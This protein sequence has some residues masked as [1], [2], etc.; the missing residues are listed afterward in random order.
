M[1]SEN[2][3]HQ[4]YTTTKEC[5]VQTDDSVGESLNC[6]Y[7]S[8][9]IH[10]D[11]N[12]FDNL[13]S[14]KHPLIVE[15]TLITLES[16]LNAKDFQTSRKEVLVSIKNHPTLPVKPPPPTESVKE[17]ED[18]D[19][20]VEILLSTETD[21]TVSS[22]NQQ[23]EI[24]T[25]LNDLR[26]LFFRF[27]I[28]PK[29]QLPPAD[30]I[31]QDDYSND[32]YYMRR[33][34]YNFEKYDPIVDISGPTVKRPIED[35]IVEETKDEDD[36]VSQKSFDSLSSKPMTPLEKI[37]KLKTCFQEVSLPDNVRLGL[38]IS[39]IALNHRITSVDDC[40]TY[41]CNASLKV[42][43]FFQVSEV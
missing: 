38:R 23:S 9:E 3:D 33:N 40:V 1:N 15:P 10:S 14:T 5:C 25:N 16:L 34:V 20:P 32:S 18:S 31:S 8:N 41:L 42:K 30:T 4:T 11:P 24:H 7:N 29:K 22:N 43:I 2:S 35:L 26:N 19:T 28:E 39:D 12:D 21:L 36:N 6:D 17:S 13:F 27:K 37:D